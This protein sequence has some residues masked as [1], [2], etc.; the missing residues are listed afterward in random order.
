MEFDPA[1]IKCTKCGEPLNLFFQRTDVQNKVK[2][3]VINQI[4]ERLNDID[5]KFNAVKQMFDN[6]NKKIGELEV[7]LAALEQPMQHPQRYG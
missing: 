7:R 1:I 5:G 6:V 3:E 2:V 4:Q